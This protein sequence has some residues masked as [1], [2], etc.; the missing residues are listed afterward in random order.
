MEHKSTEISEIREKLEFLNALSKI[1]EERISVGAEIAEDG[2]GE[3]LTFANIVES[4]SKLAD[5]I[6]SDYKDISSPPVLVSLMDGGFIFAS[7]LQN[8]LIERGFLF[9][10]TTMQVGSYEFSESGTVKISAPPKISF[11]ERNVI[12]V[13]EVWDTG[14]TFAAVLKYAL[15]VCGAKSVDL[16]VLVDKD[17]V[18][19]SESDRELIS[20]VQPRWLYSCFTVSPDAFLIGMGLDYFGG[21]RNLRDIK[22]VS[23][24]TLPDS[25]EK[26]LLSQ[27]KPLNIR[28]QQLLSLEKQAVKSISDKKSPLLENSL[29]SSSVVIKKESDSNTM[30]AEFH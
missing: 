4:T 17:P 8:A 29:L 10:Y 22:V 26:E 7:M 14:K 3:K 1:I 9:H 15:E 6:V 2:F 13:D 28:L 18:L 16:A 12:I 23:P 21:C 27:I 24:E 19:S 30:R 5:R 25:Q 11:G 20:R